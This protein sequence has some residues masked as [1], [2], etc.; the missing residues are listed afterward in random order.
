MNK[1]LINYNGSYEYVLIPYTKGYVEE[2]ANLYPNYANLFVGGKY[3][4][5][6][7]FIGDA[8]YHFMNVEAKDENKVL[9]AL[10]KNVNVQKADV[11]VN[12]KYYRLGNMKSFLYEFIKG[13][14]LASYKFTKI[15]KATAEACSLNILTN[16]SSGIEELIN[17]AYKVAESI[18]LARDLGNMPSNMMTPA[19]FAE[20]AKELAEELNVECVVYGKKELEEMNA[21][22]LLAVSQ[23]SDCEPKM[24][25]LKYQGA[26][27]A[28]W[29]SVVGKGIT[30]DSGGYN[31]KSNGGAGMKYDMCGAANA[32]GTFSLVAKL[33]LK[34]NLLAV[35]PLTEN[36]INGKG[37]K[38]GDVFTSLSGQTIEITN[39]DAEGRLI[40]ADALSYACNEGAKYIIDMATLTGAVVGA[41]SGEYTGCF[42]NDQEFL[43]KFVSASKLSKERVWQLPICEAFEERLR[44]SDV[45][46]L[47]N[48]A[49]GGA[50]ASVAASFLKAF[51]KE[52]VSWIHLDIAATATSEGTDLRYPKGAS[53]AMIETI[54]KLLAN[55]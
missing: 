49:Q 31:I 28:P 54:A 1:V 10:L 9:I 27:D 21:G 17:E 22:A 44:K 36:M 7:L 48:S 39:T 30:F 6:D 53:G 45:A 18:Y 25:A 34:V 46:D 50:G 15:N 16:E 47:I 3:E 35:M 23:G 32:L 38:I 24:V 19:L 8:K 4:E 55:L 37:Y 2:L 29:Y 33:G 11:C 40:L 26:E 5:F 41:L 51:I 43:D 42:T 12:L 20:R 52:D 14:L 13:Y